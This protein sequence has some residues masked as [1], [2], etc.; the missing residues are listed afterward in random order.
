MRSERFQGTRHAGGLP[1]PTERCGP[2]EPA[3][4]PVSSTLSA[5]L[6]C[7]AHENRGR[8]AVDELCPPSSLTEAPTAPQCDGISQR[9]DE[10]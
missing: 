5:S 7:S 3:R 8:G 4:H 2:R 1:S 6:I 9:G 10:G